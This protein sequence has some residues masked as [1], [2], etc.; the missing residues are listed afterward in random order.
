MI[1]SKDR[2]GGVLLLIFFAGYGLAGLGIELPLV[3]Q[4]AMFNAKSLPTALTLIGLSGGLWLV[5]KPADQTVAKLAG[6]RWIHAATFLALMSAYG[7]TIRPLGFVLTTLL[8]LS[9][10]FVS[11]GERRPIPVI[12]TATSITGGFWLLMHHGLGV[13]LAPW[14]YVWGN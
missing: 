10:G 11:L 2:V 14:P 9:I 1:W 8:F 13:Y 12:A 5:C 7:L 3:Q 6:L 4:G